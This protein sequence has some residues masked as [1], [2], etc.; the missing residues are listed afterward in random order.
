MP[1][2]AE[3]LFR[4]FSIAGLLLVGWLLARFEAHPALLGVVLLISLYLLHAGTD[5]L[6]LAN[7]VVT[8]WFLIVV[9]V[10]PWPED[11]VAT[12]PAEHP[13]LWASLLFGMWF[14]CML[15]SIGLAQTSQRQRL[16]G[17]TLPQRLLST[18]SPAAAAAL[19]GYWIGLQ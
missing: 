2:P 18:L 6:V 14:A 12:A 15:C 1:T 17:I 16:A 19:G 4:S 3:L 5:A 9:R 13:Q 11:W 10:R 7:L 8:V